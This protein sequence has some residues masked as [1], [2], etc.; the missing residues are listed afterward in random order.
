[1]SGDRARRPATLVPGTLSAAAVHDESADVVRPTPTSAKSAN[2]LRRVHVLTDP[3]KRS[4]GETSGLTPVRSELSGNILIGGTREEVEAASRATTVRLDSLGIVE[5]ARNASN[6]VA[7]AASASTLTQPATSA[8]PSAAT[9]PAVPAEA[10]PP[11]SAPP[12]PSAP[13]ASAPPGPPPPPRPPSAVVRAAAPSRP[14]SAAVPAASRPQSAA[15]P[16][17][18]ASA[19]AG[20]GAPA[21]RS[22]AGLFATI[23]PSRPTSAIVP[24]APL[25]SRPPSAAMPAADVPAE[26]SSGSRRRSSA[27]AMAGQGEPRDW[28]PIPP[29]QDLLPSTPSVAPAPVPVTALAPTPARSAPPTPVLI[30]VGVG[31]LIIL[32]L[33]LT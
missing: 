6:L 22:T 3:V 16:A 18:P 5:A 15:V 33:W 29:I 20:A 23:P 8:P 31:V 2:N 17:A 13:P 1:M 21:V 10:A 32:V 11:A 14:A 25:A 30:A 24:A 9:P 4:S 26:R 28:G 19:T 27:L 7:G 12:Q